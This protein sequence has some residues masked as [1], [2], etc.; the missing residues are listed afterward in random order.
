MLQFIF[1][2]PASGK[3]YTV[4]ERIKALSEKGEK[5]VVIV[6]EQFSFETERAVLK[7]LGDKAALSTEVL[8]FSRIYDEVS[9]S[10]GG[11]A[12]RVLGDCDKIIFMKRALES[13]KD[14]LTL[15]GKYTH[16][17]SF[18]KTM[19]DSVGEM[20]IN[21]VSSAKLREIAN[22]LDKPTLKLKLNDMA[23]V[24]DAYDGFI[25]E[26]FIDPADTLTKLYRTLGDYRYFEG[27]TVFLDSFKGFT[28]QQFKL[29]ERIIAQSR[30][31]YV[32]LTN[33]VANT[34]EYSVYTNIKKAA[35]SIEAIARKY[36]V[37]IAEPIITGESRF[38]SETLKCAEKIISSK[39]E[40]EIQNDGSISICAAATPV[41]EAQFATRTIRKLVREEDFRYRDFVIITRDAESYAEA[42]RTA[43]EKN[44]I[45]VFYDNRI[46]LSSFPLAVAGECALNAL[47]FSTEAIL[48][49]HKTTMGT[50]SADEISQLEN[51]AY[52]WNIDGKLWDSEWDM[53]PLG[54][55]NDYDKEK[56]AEKLIEINALR[57]KAIAPIKEFKENFCGNARSLA[58]A[59]F[60]LFESCGAAEKLK[61]MAVK[62]SGAGDSFSKDVLKQSYNEYIKILESVV[63][64]FGEAN[65]KKEEFAET[66][67]LAVSLSDV[68]VI[69]QTLD[70]VTFGAADRIRTLRPKVAFILGAN[71]GIFP[72]NTSNSGIFNTAERKLLIENDINV[73]DNSVYT[74]IDEEYLVYSS[75]C[76]ASEKLYI[77][78]S[79]QSLPG[80]AKEPSTF[81]GTLKDRLNIE[82]IKEPQILSDDNAPETKDTAF[83]EFC[84]R[85][86]GEPDTALSI[87]EAL[88]ET[89]V[90]GKIEF[91]ENSAQKN[92]VSITPKTAEQLF[93]KD[94]RM[95]AS[96]FDNFNR[97]R[98]SYFCRY[99]LKAQK[100]Q[101]ADF[102][103]MQ[104]GTIVHFV[105]ERLVNDYKDGV[106]DLSIAD[107]S[108]L[109][110]SYIN[111]YIGSIS[112][113]ESVKNEKTDFLIS[114]ISRSLKEVVRHIANEIL[115]SN[116]EPFACELKIGENNSFSFPYSSGR[117]FLNGSIDRVDKYDG[118]IRII[119]YKTGAKSFKLPDILFGLNLQML[120][121]LYAVTRGAG[122]DDSAAAGIL[123]QPSKRN[124]ND[125]NLAMNGLLQSN[126]ELYKAMDKDG[127]A[128]F[129]PPLVF[130][131]DGSLSKRSA[132]YIEKEGFTTIFDYIEK[133]M[134]KTGDT[135]AQGDIGISPLDG[136]ESPACKYC[137]FASVCGIENMEIPRVPDLKND[138][139]FEQ[140]K[141]A[142][143]DGI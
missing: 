12:G 125:N 134:A 69:P 64:C 59:L 60:K 72:Q 16:S 67:H 88:K 114:R 22:T 8:S 1:G 87:K 102:D 143:T 133:L 30:D 3:T 86:K 80:E 126:A 96:R 58:K 100:L 17:V 141:E 124:T 81:V 5:C 91:V 51:Y 82:I 9:R 76:V 117:I 89:N 68:G 104:R 94:I 25:G 113:F 122:L 32:S 106:I 109:T 137:D 4:L 95:S 52:L 48:R 130:N 98:F 140:M 47:K 71:Q 90:L 53:N 28:G 7:V 139:V 77:S 40:K 6:P 128:E 78:Y 44:D 112:G 127:K 27:K 19:L 26:K 136:R 63:E 74:A 35:L 62:F 123:Y 18:A 37:K 119:D 24:Y 41:D 83:S 49:F 56:C 108:A 23:L 97:C 65:I 85:L 14:E 70:A 29:I 118:Y 36:G 105:L 45:A 75:L 66:L 54:L 10:F 132:S 50:L 135:I 39:E 55:T 142:E 73:S 138:E 15:W 57:E 92:S 13:V 103:V 93:G 99:G 116:F 42:V 33:D 46:P 34:D 101:P 2:K 79:Q 111:E 11:I 38:K 31:V 61:E 115:Q 84:L 129:V 43:A 21:A 110:D 120:I 121:Y 20:K 131:K 107:L